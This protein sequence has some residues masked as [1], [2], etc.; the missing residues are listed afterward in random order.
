MEQFYVSGLH[1][2]GC[3][4][5]IVKTLSA[6]PGITQVTLDLSTGKLEVTG[7][8]LNRIQITEAVETAGR[9]RIV[10]T[11]SQVVKFTLPKKEKWIVTKLKLFRPLI[12]FFAIVT[13]FTL[14]RQYVLGWSYHTAMLDFMGG[15]FLVFGGLKVINWKSFAEGFRAYDPIAKRSK[16]YAYLYPAIEFLLGVAYVA[17]IRWLDVLNVT[18]IIILGFTSVGVIHTLRKGTT[19]KCACLGGFFNIPISGVTV[20]ENLLMIAMALYMLI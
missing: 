15:F 1:C 11:A 17:R 3:V 2:E 10:E 19:P 4:N 20:F 8:N 16:I 7:T 6:L 18:T 5:T 13:L 12:T 14:L 9:W